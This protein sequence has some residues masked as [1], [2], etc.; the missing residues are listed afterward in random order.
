MSNAVLEAMACAVPFLASEVGGS[1]E[2]ALSGAGWLVPGGS[3]PALSAKMRLLAQSP[4]TR[5]ISGRQARRY[6][7]GRYSWAGSAE[8]LEQ[9][10]RMHLGVAA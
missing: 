5:E 9:I 1:R 3:Q 6:V 10:V 4:A 8:R 2:L 7:Q